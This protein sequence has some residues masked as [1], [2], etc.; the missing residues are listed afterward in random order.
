M[1]RR[2]NARWAISSAFPGEKK[3]T[4]GGLTVLYVESKRME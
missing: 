3:P 4:L 1:G 2:H